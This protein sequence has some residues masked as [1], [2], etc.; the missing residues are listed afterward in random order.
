MNQVIT[1]LICM[2]AADQV[3]G[4]NDKIKQ[5]FHVGIVGFLVLTCIVIH[6]HNTI[7]YAS[8]Y[9]TPSTERGSGC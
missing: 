8:L 3:Q 2:K 6:A 1:P 9:S 5:T 7:K 4:L